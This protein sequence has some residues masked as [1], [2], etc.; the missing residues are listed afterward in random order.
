MYANTWGPDSRVC[1]FHTGKITRELQRNTTN[2]CILSLAV[3]KVQKWACNIW[4]EGA[5]KTQ[6]R[7][8]LLALL[9]EL[10]SSAV[11]FVPLMRDPEVLRATLLRALSWWEGTEWAGIYFCQTSK[12]KRNDKSQLEVESGVFVSYVALKAALA[13][14]SLE[15]R[16]GANS[17]P[18][19]VGTEYY[20]M[21]C[22]LT[23]LVEQPRF[24]YAFV[25][26]WEFIISP[27]KWRD[28][29]EIAVT[30]YPC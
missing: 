22:Q 21:S 26:S 18:A 9:P 27:C 24:C 2:F 29:T 17:T 19:K 8:W 20:W 13:I 16:R 1:R 4:D 25:K 6:P 11:V 7:I 10:R 15:E 23:Q 12:T 14:C 28:S 3:K 30:I 5:A